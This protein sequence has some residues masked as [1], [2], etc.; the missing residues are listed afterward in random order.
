MHRPRIQGANLIEGGLC[1]PQDQRLD[2]GCGV[3]GRQL[4]DQHHQPLEFLLQGVEQA[5]LFNAGLFA[6][7][8]END[9]HGGDNNKGTNGKGDLAGRHVGGLPFFVMCV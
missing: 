6:A 8:D 2:I 4:R 5:R 9:D 7:A 3:L 1:F